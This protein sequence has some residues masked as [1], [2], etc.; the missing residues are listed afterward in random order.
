MVD[1]SLIYIALNVLIIIALLRLARTLLT[2]RAERQA[3]RQAFDE[4]EIARAAA[5]TTPRDYST[6]TCPLCGKYDAT[7][8]FISYAIDCHR[9]DCG[10]TQHAS[11]PE[12]H[13]REAWDTQRG[14]YG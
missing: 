10:A 4:A 13:E 6:A 11:G 2:R 12:P 8:P 5:F 1:S 7:R 14:R 9:K 3:K